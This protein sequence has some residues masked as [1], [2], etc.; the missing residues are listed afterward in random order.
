[1][2]RTVN[3]Q[4]ERIYDLEQK[5]NV[6]KKV[7]ITSAIGLALIS[8]A[9]SSFYIVDPSDRA[10]VR[11]FGQLTTTTPI[12]P[13]LHFKVPF[14]STVDKL[15]VSLTTLHM[16][17]FSTNTVDNQR[18]Q[19]EINMTYRIPEDG[20]FRLMYDTGGTGPGDITNQIKSVVRDRVSRVV[21]SKN[22]NSISGDR[23]KIQNEIFGEVEKSVYDLFRI[24]VESLQIPGIVYSET[25]NSS[26]EAAVR[27]KNE[28]IA[29]ENRKKVF[30]YQ[31]QQKVITAE[32]EAKQA[33]VRAEGE[34]KSAAIA[35]QGA[36]NALLIRAQAEEKAAELAGQGNAA[37]LS[38]EIVALGGPDKYLEL[39][40]TIATQKWNGQGPATVMSTNGQMPMLLNMPGSK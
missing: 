25:F 32:G 19:L 37:R 12:G 31:A 40:R 38:A 2:E 3:Y 6:I 29:E 34:A 16:E 5:V 1:M 10:G 21:A 24:K 11:S 20:V 9:L 35:A 4:E 22:T 8:T 7:V 17:P 14:F 36:A 18:V 28:A 26:V 39:Q 13:G 23:E 15:Q 33:T 30:E 27:A